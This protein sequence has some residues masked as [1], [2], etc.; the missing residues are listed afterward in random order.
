MIQNTHVSSSVYWLLIENRDSRWL[1]RQFHISASHGRHFGPRA[2]PESQELRSLVL[3]HRVRPCSWFQWS[4]SYMLWPLQVQVWHASRHAHLCV[5]WAR[6]IWSSLWHCFWHLFTLAAQ[7]CARHVPRA[8]SFL[9]FQWHD[10]RWKSWAGGNADLHVPIGAY[11]MTKGPDFIH[12]LV[13]QFFWDGHKM[14]KQNTI[15][16]N[17]VQD[18]WASQ[19]P[20]LWRF[21]AHLPR[22]RW[23]LTMQCWLWM[24]VAIFRSLCPSRC[25]K[26]KSLWHVNRRD[27]PCRRRAGVDC[28][29][30]GSQARGPTKLL[31]KWQAEQS[32][33]QCTVHR[34]NTQQVAAT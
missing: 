32:E 9:L 2:S 31:P 10:R 29:R 21:V 11:V 17:S 19:F 22:W 30:P 25:I 5:A 6:Q 26:G 23:C 18:C 20:Q 3:Q 33:H 4:W 7:P 15:L 8:L 16:G 13:Y 1:T 12:S 24:A 28:L 27:G 14:V 34:Y